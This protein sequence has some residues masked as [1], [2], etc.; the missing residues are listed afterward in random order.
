LPTAAQKPERETA[1]KRAAPRSSVVDQEVEEAYDATWHALYVS[2][3]E[4]MQGNTFYFAHRSSFA[5]VSVG[6]RFELFQFIWTVKDSQGAP[7]KEKRV[8]WGDVVITEL[9]DDGWRPVG[10]YTGKPIAQADSKAKM[11]GLVY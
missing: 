3:L 4:T 7:I 6:D 11:F 8:K 2:N 9:L 1:Q 5:K 10:K